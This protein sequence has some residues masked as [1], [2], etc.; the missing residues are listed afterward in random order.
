VLATLRFDQIDDTTAENWLPDH[1]FVG[2]ILDLRRVGF[3]AW[4]DALMHGREI[5]ARPD[6][7]S[8]DRELT[9]LLPALE[10][11]AVVGASSLAKIAGDAAGVRRLIRATLATLRRGASSDLDLAL[12]AVELA[13]LDRAAPHERLAERLSVSRSTFYR[14]LRRGTRALA[15]ALSRGPEISP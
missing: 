15:E 14:L 2:Y 8:L 9:D 6:A 5:V 10:D 3:E 12:R 1:P 7:E 11:D 13:Y 4:I